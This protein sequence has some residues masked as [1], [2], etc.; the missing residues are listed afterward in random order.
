MAPTSAGLMAPTR[1]RGAHGRGAEPTADADR[2]GVGDQRRV[3]GGGRRLGHPD[4]E[5]GHEER[6]GVDGQARHEHEHSERRRRTRAMIGGRRKRSASHPIGSA[7][8]TMKAVEAA[9]M[10][11]MTPS[12]TPKVL[13]MSGASTASVAPSKFS[14]HARASSM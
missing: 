2:I 11:T 6:E 10:N 12:L 5:P 1:R 3:D 13:R 8:T 14:T 7:P 9:V 4:A